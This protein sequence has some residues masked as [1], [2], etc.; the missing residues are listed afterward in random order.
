MKTGVT[1]RQ[2][3]TTDDVLKSAHQ[4]VLIPYLTSRLNNTIPYYSNTNK[5]LH[6]YINNSISNNSTRSIFDIPE[7]MHRAFHAFLL[8]SPNGPNNYYYNN[9]RAGQTMQQCP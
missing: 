8:A 1:K 2:R 6:S 3:L 9:A 7:E 5:V 4:R